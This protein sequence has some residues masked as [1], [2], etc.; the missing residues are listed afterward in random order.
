MLLLV[1]LS[2]M[3]GTSGCM[4]PP[5]LTAE[6]RR[7]D[8]EFLAQWARDYSPLVELNENHKGTPSYEA[9]LPQYA[10]FAAQAQSDD[11]FCLIVLQYF[12]VIGASGHAY[13]LPDNSLK[14]ASVGSLLGVIN[15][16][17]T[18]WQFQRA[19]YWTKLAD[20]LSLYAHPPF[21][22]INR[23]DRYFTDDDWQYEGTAVPQGSEILKV[24]GMTCSDYL[25]FLKTDT[26]LKYSAYKDS[27]ASN[28][29]LI[30]DEGPSFH[31]WSV[32]DLGLAD[33]STLQV[34]VPKLK[35]WPT[36][37]EQ[38]VHTKEPDANCTCLELTEDVG[39]IRIKSFMGHPVDVLL[40]RN[41]KRESKQIRA[42][43]ERS[44]GKYGK[45]IIDVRNNG[46]GDPAYWYEN[47]VCPFL[48][49]PVNYRHTAG[50]KRRFLKDAKPPILR[51]LRKFLA[52]EYVID[53]KEVAP[54]EGFDSDEWVFYEIT[55]RLDPSQR[56]PFKGDMYVLINGGCY[57]ACDD[58][59]QTVK[60]IGMATLVGQTTGGCGGI[61]YC[62]N[63]LVRLPKS[64]MM[65]VLDVHLP[66]NPNGSFT[67]LHGLDPD[68][69]LPR[70]DLPKSI[71]KED[72]LKDEWI[73]WILADAQECE[74]CV[75]RE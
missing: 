60:R 64:G 14:W 67:A 11:E 54:A 65:F 44:R 55:R 21:R 40:K 46:G 22:I 45:L 48:D 36:P 4:S 28:H 69:E 70:A 74:D 37:K 6:D 32:V 71:T 39:Y 49:Q 38:R 42:F 52:Q 1:T 47:L 25:D 56:F 72:L 7:S 24:N 53:T 18:P 23:E 73:K 15:F 13:Q 30:V 29:L 43:L 10:E 50:L 33:G 59:A 9:L 2:T 41:V 35:G 8:I 58:Y 27:V 68:I 5:K 61:G 19:R 75:D 12:K 66:L 34:S 17:I 3:F 26:W 31:G 16:G 62:M 57:S 20:N 51:Q 63:S